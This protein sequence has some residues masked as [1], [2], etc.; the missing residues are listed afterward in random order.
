MPHPDVGDAAYRTVATSMSK[1][2]LPPRHR[3][4]RKEDEAIST[5]QAPAKD[6]ATVRGPQFDLEDSAFPPLPGKSC[7]ERENS[8]L[9][10]RFSHRQT[11]GLDGGATI[12]AKQTTQ[13]H[14]IASE[15]VY[16]HLHHHHHL[17]QTEPSQQ[18]QNQGHWGE[19][20][21]AD[22][23]KGTVKG[24][25]GKEGGGSNPTSPRATSPQQGY[26]HTVG[27]HHHHQRQGSIPG[28]AP[29]C[30]DAASGN[31]EVHLSV[32]T[33]TPPSSPDK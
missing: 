33:I 20:R 26:H 11:E 14:A 31:G 4:K 1:E 15:P 10:V 27:H 21:L 24:K 28:V 23:V 30:K 25:G 12:A 7:M 32:V 3:R 17:S 9:Y 2:Q 16:H 6:A 18:Q 13:T 8:L 22:V 19:N 5:A 29:E